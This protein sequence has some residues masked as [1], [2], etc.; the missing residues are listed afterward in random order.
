MIGEQLPHF[1]SRSL[2]WL[3]RNLFNVVLVLD[4]SHPDAIAAIKVADPYLIPI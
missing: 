4:L 2:P 3:K 1:A